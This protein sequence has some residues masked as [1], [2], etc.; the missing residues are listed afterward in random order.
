MGFEVGEIGPTRHPFLQQADVV[1]LHELE[2]SV[3]VGLNPAADIG[4]AL[5][6]HAALF[7]KS[8]VDCLRVL[9]AKTFDHH[10]QHLRSV[11]PM[12]LIVTP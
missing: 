9:V 11:P 2:T 3:E 6:R 8:L 1:A 10:E 4:Q 5:G 7:L 12:S